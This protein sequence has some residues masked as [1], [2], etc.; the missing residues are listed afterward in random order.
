MVLIFD[1]KD[2][3]SYLEKRLSTTGKNRG[4]RT[5]LAEKLNCNLA[6]ISQVIRG[7]LNFSL[8]HAYL[9]S[10]FLQHSEAEKKYFLLMILAERSGIKNLEQ[11]FVDQLND[12]NKGR[13]EIS[14]RIK[15][16]SLLSLKAKIKYYST[17]YYSAIHM[18]LLIP[19]C[20][21]PE[22]LAESLKLPL[23]LVLEVLSF[24][25]ESGLAIHSK[26]KYIPGNERMHLSS[27][28]EMIVQH[29][30]NWRNRVLRSFDIKN[31][32]DIHYSG[33]IVT[34]KE[35][36]EKIREIVLKAI[37]EMESVIKLPGEEQTYGI[38][39]DFFEL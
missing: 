26:G 7:H 38:C 35:N 5:K 14:E 20:H 13:R 4:A 33:A 9:T 15:S 31:S 25:V 27:D 39:L 18:S 6:Y 34:T 24:L 23:P 10:D 32:K 22:H 29:H 19:K 12:I 1:F 11:H 28:S 30:T 2:Y 3:R 36:A 37:E 21:V 16:D 17:W 8:E